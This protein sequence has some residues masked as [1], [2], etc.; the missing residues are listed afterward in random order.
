MLDALL[1]ALREGVEAALVVGIVLL[2]LER[3]GRRQLA[4]AVW[5]GVILAVLASGAVAEVLSRWQ[6]SQDGFEGLLMVTAAVFV[7]SMIVWMN[8][9]AR[10]LRKEI[11]QKIEGFTG[12]EGWAAALG[13]GAFVFLL[14][15]REGVELALIL[16]A[17]EF[18]TAGLAVG[19]GTALGLALAV[20]VGVSFFNGTLR[21]PLGRFFKA[22]SVIL[23]VVA[24]QLVVT[25]LHEMSEA[26]WLPSSRWE[27]AIIGPIVTNEVFFFVIVLGVALVLAAREWSS[28][29]AA[30]TAEGAN[31]AERRRAEWEQKR[32]RRWVVGMATICA[33][34]LV[35]LSAEFVYNRAEA[36]PPPAT[37][38]AASGQLVRVPIADLNGGRG[39][40][41]YS[42]TIGGT[43][44][45]F[46]VVHRAGGTFQAALDACDIC[47]TAG[48]VMQGQ[49]LICRLCGSVIYIPT[50]GMRGGCN[51]IALPSH[52]ENGSLVID[53]SHMAPV[54]KGMRM[55]SAAPGN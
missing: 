27:M 2:Y 32:Q 3:T 51:P 19:I 34:V 55:S 10:H 16:R 8:R 43:D 33:V 17:M 52:V 22:T 41:F 39:V 45:R 23:T 46:I 36:A 6:V 12:R 29:R 47:G 44:L 14:V 18:S 25:G 24:V 30:K 38:V 48:Y 49:N 40:H 42:T 31:A 50:V 21:V 11:E 13:V 9:V 15:V 1:I 20:I 26:L 53:F 5:T 54:H 7:V 37:A 35:A 4:R 28:L